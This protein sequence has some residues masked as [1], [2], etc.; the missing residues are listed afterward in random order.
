MNKPVAYLLL[1]ALLPFGCARALAAGGAAELGFFSYAPYGHSLYADTHPNFVRLDVALCANNEAYDFGRTSEG[2]RWTTLGDFGVNLPLW[3]GDLREGRFG[4]NVTWAMS[5]QLWL[6]ILEPVTSPV[7][8]TD[9]R[10]GIPTVTFLHRLDRGFA[11][12]Y[13]VAWSP[14]KHES[15]HIGDELQIQR[16]KEG[17][18]LNRVN[19]SYN[20]TE[21]SVTLNEPEDRTRRTHTFRAGVMLL[22]VPG[23]GW[24]SVKEEA[25]DGDASLAH[26][27]VSPWEA[28]LQYQFQTNTHPSGIQGV[29]S[30]EIRDRAV[31]G[32]DLTLRE[33]E[34]E[35]SPVS[36]SRRLTFN[37][38]AG[39]GYNLPGYDGY[40]SRFT[41]GVRAYRG[42]C[43]YGQFRGIDRYSQIGLCL[44]FQ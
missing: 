42:N 30:A 1:S 11:R 38:F 39:V 2:Y 32:Y 33:G 9:Y 26:P 29:V 7:I 28:Y 36:D 10:I 8:N 15:T 17:Y 16:V 37:L 6:D 25:G 18:A 14:F 21:L 3:H 22:L 24:Y 31:Y 27:R 19:V 40:F 13:S 34:E 43:P 35:T 23:K 20:Y 12:N 4:F 41:A 5:A 44:I